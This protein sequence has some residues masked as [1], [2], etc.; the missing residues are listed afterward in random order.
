ME[1]ILFMS[2]PITDGSTERRCFLRL[3]IIALEY[4]VLLESAQK[5]LL[6]VFSFTCNSFWA[7]L[8]YSTLKLF[9]GIDVQISTI[10]IPDN[11]TL[12]CFPLDGWCPEGK[13]K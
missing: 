12:V 11:S 5:G 4:Q 10:C 7:R 1:S 6:F 3:K 2:A 9:N 13:R 8:L